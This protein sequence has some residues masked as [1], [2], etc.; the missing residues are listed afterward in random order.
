MATRMTIFIVAFAALHG[1]AEA[2]DQATAF[3]YQGELRDAGVSANGSY[4]IGASLWTDPTGGDQIGVML[5]YENVQVADGRF[6]LELDWGADAFDNSGRW[7]E[8]SVDGTLL[9]PRQ[10]LTRT[11]YAIQTRGIFVGDD[12]KVGLGRSNPTA[13][14]DVVSDTAGSGNNTARFAAPE[15]GSR[16]SHVHYGPNGDWYIRSATGDGAVLIQ[17]TGG[18]VGI[19]TGSPQHPLHIDAFVSDPAL[20]VTNTSEIFGVDA[21]DGIGVLADKV[22]LQ[23]YS[24]SLYAAKLEGLDYRAYLGGFGHSAGSFHNAGGNHIAVLASDIR[25]GY[26]KGSVR[27]D[28]SLTKQGG[29]FQIDHPLDPENRFLSHSFVESPDMKNIYDGRIV[30]DERGYAIVEL[31]AYFEALNRD[32]RYQL[33]VI[34]EFVQAIVAEEIQ[35]NRFVIRTEKPNI[36]VSW[37][38]TGI[39]DDAYARLYPVIVE[40]DKAEHERGLYLAP[41]AFGM[42]KER[43]LSWHETNGRSTVAAST[44]R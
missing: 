1:L 3:T 6:V 21:G 34:G 25:A 36:Q 38:V 2:A 5:A 23:V 33:T 12:G 27:I 41:E 14:L 40:M 30:T 18:K 43:G 28:G 35:D 19:G 24:N 20:Q 10:A 13:R 11:P 29:T 42:P 22:G 44:N 9:A 37:M 32:F 17:D 26:F 8:L 15:I 4:D 39:R 7:L 16:V 31:P